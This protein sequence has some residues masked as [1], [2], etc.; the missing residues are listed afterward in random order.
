MLNADNNP[1][2]KLECYKDQKLSLGN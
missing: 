1:I 2:I